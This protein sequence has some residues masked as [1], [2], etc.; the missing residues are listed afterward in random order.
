MLPS[1]PPQEASWTTASRVRVSGSAIRT[2]TRVSHPRSSGDQHGVDPGT[3]PEGLGGA[4]PCLAVGRPV[5]GV[6][7]DATHRAHGRRTIT[8]AGAGYRSA[9]PFGVMVVPGI[10]VAASMLMQPAA[11]VTCTR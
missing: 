11:L 9:A 6:G 4:V 1:Q 7:A 2:L 8:L 3:E 5:E 10:T